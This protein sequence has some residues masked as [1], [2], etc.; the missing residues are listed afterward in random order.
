MRSRSFAH[1]GDN[2]CERHLCLGPEY[3]RVVVDQTLRG[4]LQELR[5]LVVDEVE[6][7]RRFSLAEATIKYGHWI[8]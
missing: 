6:T 8:S 4:D 5:F 3:A 7:I 1:A 2:P